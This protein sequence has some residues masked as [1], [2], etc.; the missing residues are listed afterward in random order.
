MTSL[1]VW[2]SSAVTETVAE[3]TLLEN[4]TQNVMRQ[5]VVTIS[6]FRVEDQFLGFAG[7]DVPSQVTIPFS[8]V[9]EMFV[10]GSP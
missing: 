3:K 6:H 7:S 1:E 4:V 9:L 8:P 10:P 2:N 5:V